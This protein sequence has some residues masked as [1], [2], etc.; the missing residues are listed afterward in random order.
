MITYWQ[1]QTGGK[2]VKAK[3][4]EID[5]QA[6]TWV[7]ARI[8]TRDD[9]EQL[10]ENYG[11]DPEH[12]LDILDPDELS[13]L[14]DGDDYVLTILRLPI[15]EPSAE[16]PYFTIPLGIIM[17]D[18]VIITI[19]WTDCEV[20]RDFATGR[21]KG[22]VLADFPAFIMRI[23]GRSNIT[24]LRY[25]KEINRRSTAIQNELQLS[26][27]NK[28]II[29]L[30]SLEKSLVY[31]TTSLKSNQLLLEKFHKTKLIKLDYDDMDWLE[32]VE[33]D[34]KQ[35]IEMADTYRNVLMG[36]TDTFDSVISNNLNV[37][38]KRLSILN[39]IMMVPT[40][41]TSFFGMNVDLPFVKYG[42][43]AVWIITAIC[44]VSIF[45]TNVILGF[46]ETKYPRKQKEPKKS[47][48]QK[49]KERKAARRLKSIEA[50]LEE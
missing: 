19:C 11:I 40:F 37:Y 20:L 35:A 15:F 38:M 7:D 23:I 48:T 27:E 31:F 10:Q 14:E 49:R 32:D 24:F 21:A 36:V 33:I 16:T 46:Y 30:L 50:A 39:I 9:V 25:L 44:L 5:T 34:N 4:D 18:N 28:E 8:V 3:E 17:K 29:Q 45:I 13:R 22:I 26:I 42:R 47:I 41:I 43:L 1:Q 12:I 6:R 2:L